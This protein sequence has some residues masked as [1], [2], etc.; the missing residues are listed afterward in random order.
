MDG[1]EPQAAQVF[2]KLAQD[3]PNDGLVQF[4]ATRLLNGEA[5]S[6]IVMTSK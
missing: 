4:H 6:T 3:Y 2:G 1:L 5:G